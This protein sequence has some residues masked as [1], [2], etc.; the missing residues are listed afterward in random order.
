MNIIHDLI[1]DILTL[2]IFIFLGMHLRK[3]VKQGA[4]WH[5]GLV[6]FLIVILLFIVTDPISI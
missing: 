6:W 2:G 1:P 5:H 4:P 3:G